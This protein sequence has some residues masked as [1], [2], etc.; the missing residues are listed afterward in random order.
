MDR[1]TTPANGRVAAL[2][3]K[4]QVEAERFVEGESMQIRAS[5]T[6][7]WR[8]ASTEK[9]ER[10]LLFGDVFTVL[11]DQSGFA[12]GQSVKDGYCGYVVSDDLGAMVRPTHIVSA[13]STHLYSASC[14]KSPYVMAISFG[15]HLTVTEDTGKLVRT[16]DGHY[17]PRIHLR[18]ID[19]PF[20][21]P[22]SVAEVFLGAPYLWAGNSSFGL[23]CSGLVQAALQACGIA[24]P[25]DSDLQELALGEPLPDSAE[26]KRGDLFFW[27]GHVAMA[28]DDTR[29]IHANGHTMSVAYE[30]TRDAIKR[31]EAAGDG[32]VTS[33]RRL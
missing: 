30:N 31:I 16:R 12:F 13:R 3:L 22:I 5:M 4:G 29:I 27:K 33:R 25:G 11:E 21:D 28:V 23:D 7:I 8:D 15:S 2:H 20:D 24:C 14:I 32:P 26:T 1:R 10:Q 19:S 18:E 9:P 6:T 17:V